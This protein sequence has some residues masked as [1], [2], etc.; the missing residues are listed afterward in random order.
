[1][2]PVFHL[3]LS[4]SDPQATRTFY[5]S[6]FGARVG[7]S[8]EAWIDIWLFGTQLTAYHR[9]AAVTP[10]PYREAQHFGATVSWVDW[11]ALVAR[12]GAVAGGFA[13]APVVDDVKGQAKA[14]VADPDGYLIEIKA[15]RDPTLTLQRP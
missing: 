7:R 15:Y 1:M 2:E 9:P 11:E 3:S 12:A 14:I 4:V 5:E 6:A 8:T 10:S 13:T